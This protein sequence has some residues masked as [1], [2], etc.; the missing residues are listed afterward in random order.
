MLKFVLYV[1]LTYLLVRAV[2]NLLRAMV[3]QN[4]VGPV[5]PRTGPD[6]RRGGEAS[7]NGRSPE[8]DR[9]TRLRD[10]EDIEDAKWEDL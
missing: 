2:V 9:A 7:Q 8:E 1:I 6:T 3:V 10:E 5:P 4:D